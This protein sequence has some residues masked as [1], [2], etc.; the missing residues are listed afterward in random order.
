M[1]TH[2]QGNPIRPIISQ[3]PT[4][5]YHISKILNNIIVPYIPNKYSIKSTHEFIQ[6]LNSTPLTNKCITASLDV[7]NLFTNVPVHETIKIIIE[8]DYNHP[9]IPPPAIQ[10]KILEKLL[11]ICTTKVPFNDPSG[12][13]Y[14]FKR[15]LTGLNSEF[16]FS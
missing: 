12:N 15:S 13:I 2:K 10:P 14:L 16:S 4:L 5:V 11:L 6:I 9:S 3:I 8:N 7:K 1:K